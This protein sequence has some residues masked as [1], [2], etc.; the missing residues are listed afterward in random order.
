MKC[1]S[2]MVPDHFFG[3]SISN[4]AE[5]VVRQRRRGEGNEG[6]RENGR[7]HGLA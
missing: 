5:T 4:M 1:I 7:L 2:V 6:R 3:T